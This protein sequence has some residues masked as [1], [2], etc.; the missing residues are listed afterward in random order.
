MILAKET[1]IYHL[2]F[3]YSFF[4]SYIVTSVSFL[5][6]LSEYVLIVR[7]IQ[8]HTRGKIGLSCSFCCRQIDS[9]SRLYTNAFAS[10]PPP[11]GSVHCSLC[12][13]ITVLLLF[14]F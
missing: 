8:N 9:I 13:S 6:I 10:M 4:L 14:Q 12:T 11:P 3:P 5:L 1:G 7:G 2:V